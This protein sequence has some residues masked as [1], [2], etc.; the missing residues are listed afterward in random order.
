MFYG[1]N[2]HLKRI[3]V[4]R[5]RGDLG[6]TSPCWNLLSILISTNRCKSDQCLHGRGNKSASVSSSSHHKH[7]GGE[8]RRRDRTEPVFIWVTAPPQAWWRPWG[9]LQARLGAKKPGEEPFGGLERWGQ[10]MLSPAAERW[11]FI[12]LSI[13]T[14]IS[15]FFFTPPPDINSSRREY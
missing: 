6:F 7:M 1:R 5:F 15:F 2:K 4:V 14:F 11:K 3:R 13:I 8:H 12:S 9:M 10:S